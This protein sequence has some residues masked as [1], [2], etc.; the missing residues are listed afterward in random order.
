[1]IKKL[2]IISGF[3]SIALMGIFPGFI[4]EYFGKKRNSE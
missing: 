1:M 3:Q 2:E 4:S